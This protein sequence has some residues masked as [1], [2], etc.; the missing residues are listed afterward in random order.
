[1]LVG[2][3]LE[4]GKRFNHQAELALDVALE[5]LGT[6][7]VSNTGT[8][9]LTFAAISVS[10]N[11]ATTSGTT[12]STATPMG[13]TPAGAYTLTVTRASGNLTHST[14]VTLN[15]QQPMVS[16]RAPFD[17]GENGLDAK[18]RQ[19]DDTGLTA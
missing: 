13:G 5:Y 4:L 17:G 12:C 6:V 2:L 3:P 1:M 15:V 11:F 7:A 18:P 14:T 19:A 9:A 16:W 10:A 8:A